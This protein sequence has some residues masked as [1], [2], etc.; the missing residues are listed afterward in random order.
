[1]EKRKLIFLKTPYSKN[2]NFVSYLF[3]SVFIILYSIFSLSIINLQIFPTIDRV[4]F[5]NASVKWTITGYQEFDILLTSLIFSV[6]MIFTF[7]KKI[8]I[9]LS[10]LII[11]FPSLS[12]ILDLDFLQQYA[13][14]SFFITFPLAIGLLVLSIVSLNQEI[15]TKPSDEHYPQGFFDFRKFLS[16]IFYLILIVEL[17]AVITWIVYPF[18]LDAP[19]QE[20]S[21]R[22]NFLENNLFYAFG[23]LSS[24]L[25]LLSTLFFVIKPSF[26]RLF[27]SHAN[28][29]PSHVSEVFENA[30]D[31]EITKMV[32]T[33]STNFFRIIENFF[34]NIMASEPKTLLFIGVVAILPSLLLSLYPY[35]LIDSE[36]STFLGTDIPSYLNWL[37]QFDSLPNNPASLLS[38]LFLEIDNGSRPFS[39]LAIRSLS[40]ITN[41]SDLTT[42]K[43]MPIL[44]GPL[45]VISTYY[46][47]RVSS[48]SNRQLAVIIAIM[49]VASHQVIIGFYAAFYANWMAIIMMI[50]S[51]TFLLKVLQ[52]DS[53]VYRNLLLY[54]SCCILVL[55]FHSYTWSY[56]IVVIS[57]FLIWSGIQGKIS[58]ESIR[59]IVILA[60]VTFSVVSIDLLKSYLGG[61]SDSFS[62]DLLNPATS[63][64]YDEFTKR[65]DNLNSTFHWYVG[66]FLTNSAVLLL[67]FLWTITSNY[68]NHFD[69]ILYSML[70]I[71]ILPVL[72]GDVVV[73]A[74][75]FY[76]IPLQIPAS[77]MMYR[78]YKN[79]KKS[80]FEKPLLFALILMQFNYA[81]RAMANMYFVPP[82]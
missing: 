26:R 46:L 60:I 75:I 74:R 41:Q 6:A 82:S 15:R 47:A 52:R 10:I 11:L 28:P 24:S 70:F 36:E 21:W 22:I 63:I 34:S 27:S 77:I 33:K 25:I 56:F 3:L 57:F 29:R 71:S 35:I 1:M 32:P 65:W 53:H 16:W 50:I 69:R 44:L 45:L 2:H 9:P 4:T 58:K 30:K 67:V 14:I 76:D 62:N 79:P 23:L 31:P 73:Q 43:Y 19:S 42:L 8:S 54:A 38:G 20:W 55:F 51:I 18:F 66:G 78:I 48:P 61:V 68:K 72:F 37:G 59:I 12:I 13:E 39:L 7:K 40:E 81:L 80:T 49:T 5:F 64:G 17:I